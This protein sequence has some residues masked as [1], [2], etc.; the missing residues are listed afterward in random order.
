[1]SEQSNG[2]GN[3]SPAKQIIEILQLDQY[4]ADEKGISDALRLAKE[5]V[6]Q[7]R[8]YR[9]ELPGEARFRL[10]IAAMPR[11]GEIEYSAKVRPGSDSVFQDQYEQLVQAA[12]L[13][14]NTIG[15][16]VKTEARVIGE[17][18]KI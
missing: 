7:K 11:G 12:K 16:S 14:E 1:M 4:T 3:I 18:P 9:W 8:P 10:I 17:K 15:I 5:A 2:E 6:S 13:I